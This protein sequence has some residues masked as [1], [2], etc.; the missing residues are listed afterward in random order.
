MHSAEN[1]TRPWLYGKQTH[2]PVLCLQPYNGY[3]GINKK[4]NQNLACAEYWLTDLNYSHSEYS[5]WFKKKILETARA[6]QYIE[7]GVAYYLL[8]TVVL[9]WRKRVKFMT[10]NCNLA[11][12]V[13]F[14]NL[15][16]VFNIICVWMIFRK[17]W[18][19]QIINIF[20]L[21]IHYLFTLFR[22]SKS[23]FKYFLQKPWNAMLQNVIYLNNTII[24]EIIY[25]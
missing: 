12:V 8:L 20:L 1:R 21:Y 17:K 18:T 6:L 9:K 14:S 25:F 23:F 16:N 10:P 2:D 19:F 24:H 13:I 4:S 15:L 7:V 11:V 5:H 22:C 3:L